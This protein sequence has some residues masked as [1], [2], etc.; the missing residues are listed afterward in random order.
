MDKEENEFGNKSDSDLK[1]MLK[2][3]KEDVLR[4]EEEIRNR[5]YAPNCVSGDHQKMVIK[6]DKKIKDVQVVCEIHGLLVPE[7]AKEELNFI[8]NNVDELKEDY[9][10]PF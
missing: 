2:K 1:V 10:L 8:A 5:E 3:Q 7:D 9:L 6:L 4:L